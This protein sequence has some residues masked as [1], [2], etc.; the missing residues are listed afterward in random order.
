M[1]S[2]YRTMDMFFIKM[3]IPLEMGFASPSEGVKALDLNDHESSDLPVTGV[4]TRY[5]AGHVVP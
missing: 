2:I 3:D 5:P 4:V 1:M